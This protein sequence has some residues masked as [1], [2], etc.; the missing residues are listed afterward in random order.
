MLY[1]N[2]DDLMRMCEEAVTRI[3]ET[4][5]DIDIEAAATAMFDFAKSIQENPDSFRNMVS[6]HGEDR[7]FHLKVRMDAAEQ[8]IEMTP[9]EVS[10]L[11]GMCE[12]GLES[13]APED[14]RW[15]E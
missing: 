11:I 12:V 6:S 7:S 3:A 9:A 15:K 13:F 8:G 5:D 2:D 10:E 1:N 14:E 4:N